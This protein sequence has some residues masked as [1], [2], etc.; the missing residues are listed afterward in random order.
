MA[1]YTLLGEKRDLEIK[2]KILRKSGFVP[3]VVYGHHLDTLNIQIKQDV[4]VKFSQIQ[5]VGSKVILKI[6]GEEYL[7]LFKEF[8]RDPLNGKI[9]HIDFHALTAGEKVKV[10]VPIN[11]MNKDSLERDT[12]LQE[13]MRE[14]EI[15]TLPKFLIDHIDIDISNYSLGDSIF[16]SDLEISSD[17]NIEVI[18]PQTSQV[19]TIAHA[20]KFIIDLPEDEEETDEEEVI[21]TETIEE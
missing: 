17:E 18:S 3:A 11:Y 8:Q 4:A 5:S 12:V 13:Q 2:V 19:C 1:T 21:S 16:V 6:D 9:N 7:T 14:I 10:K 15:S 20:A